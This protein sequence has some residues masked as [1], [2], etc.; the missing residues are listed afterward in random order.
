[1]NKNN[2]D[3]DYL[4]MLFDS[5][6]FFKESKQQLY[7]RNKLVSFSKTEMSPYAIPLIPRKNINKT[8]HEVSKPEF[9]TSSKHNALRKIHKELVKDPKIRKEKL[10]K[11]QVVS[12][13]NLGTSEE[14]NFETYNVLNKD[15]VPKDY[16]IFKETV[17]TSHFNKTRISN[18]DVNLSVRSNTLTMSSTTSPNKLNN[19][20]TTIG[21]KRCDDIISEEDLSHTKDVSTPFTPNVPEMISTASKLPNM[22]Q[23]KFG[24]MSQTSNPTNFPEYTALRENYIRQ[25]AALDEH[26][27]LATDNGIKADIS[28]TNF[29]ALILALRKVSYRIVMCYEKMKTSNDM[30]PAFALMQK[31]LAKMGNDVHCI[32]REPFIAWIGVS[33]Y[34]NPFFS[35][36]SIDGESAI[37][38]IKK[39]NGQRLRI[40]RFRQY[41]DEV[42]VEDGENDE[43]TVM[44]MP[45]ALQLPPDEVEM[46]EYLGHIV[47]TVFR[48]FTEHESRYKVDP[49]AMM[50]GVNGNDDELD[51]GELQQQMNRQH[52]R[53]PKEW[54]K[55]V[56]RN[57]NTLTQ[58][59]LDYVNTKIMNK[60]RRNF[61]HEIFKVWR[62]VFI[63]EKIIRNNIDC[64]NWTIKRLVCKRVR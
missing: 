63:A 13:T 58:R 18:L 54:N 42:D 17:S 12:V 39:R 36:H 61:T 19:N 4:D 25:L 9:V 27:R 37:L 24:N 35:T 22:F 40:H 45:P 6:E 16:S 32:D 64:K 15:M 50:A 7:N 55:L 11:S 47:W 56:T 33:A 53:N 59:Q 1:M 30:H 46:L 62:K 44:Q 41:D 29:I 5:K 31:Y 51:N 38:G 20:N 23:K 21:D 3:S 43:E 34:H 8:G 28:I 48:T 2:G 14:N 57:D 52:H 60:E 49:I 26:E 10:K